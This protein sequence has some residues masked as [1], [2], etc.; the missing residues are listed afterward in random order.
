MP[1][2]VRKVKG[3]YCVYKKGPDGEPEGKI[4]GTHES[5]A[6]AED[7]MAAM[8]AEEDKPSKSFAMKALSMGEERRFGGILVPFGGPDDRDL[9]GEWFDG[10][11]KAV[12][13]WFKHQG[14]MPMLVD[15]EEARHILNLFGANIPDDVPVEG[16]VGKITKFIKTDEGWYAEGHMT[17]A[18]DK[19]RQ[20]FIDYVW[21]EVQKGKLNFSSTAF[22]KRIKKSKSG[23]IEEW[24]VIEG[25]A[26]WRP[27]QP[28]KTEIDVKSYKSALE[29]LHIPTLPL[30]EELSSEKQGNSS[31]KVSK[32]SESID[33]QSQRVHSAWAEL[34]RRPQ[35]TEQTWIVERYP[36]YVIVC[37]SGEEYYRV[38][39]TMTD[40]EVMFA[41]KSEW[42]HVKREWVVV[43]GDSAE[44][45]SD[46]MMMQSDEM[47]KALAL[48]RLKLLNIEVEL[49]H[50]DLSGVVG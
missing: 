7:Q 6:E 41:P 12:D 9:D 42:E 38:A 23:Y 14:A 31:E 27:A 16:P 33:E 3:Q 45:S 49:L 25:T 35:P 44:D 1:Y 32:A 18:S 36:G 28:K 13:E 47:S 4:L 30:D 5:M 26:T 21:G 48:A 10:D 8:H 24:P 37:E 15:H 40:D 50:H 11:T 22:P 39:Y 46:T 34:H 17:E 2:M 29:F 19:L 43:P 20:A